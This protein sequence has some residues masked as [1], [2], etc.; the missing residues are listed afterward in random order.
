MN[1]LYANVWHVC[2][3]LYVRLYVRAK[4]SSVTEFE[5][6]FIFI[7]VLVRDIIMTGRWVAENGLVSTQQKI[8]VNFYVRHSYLSRPDIPVFLLFFFQL[9]FFY[10]TLWSMLRTYTS[11]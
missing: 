2:V 6:N 3:C 4:K 10:F 11:A 8:R 9:P 7:I 5:H 1:Y